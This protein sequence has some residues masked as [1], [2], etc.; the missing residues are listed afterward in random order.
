VVLTP[1]G[2]KQMFNKTHNTISTNEFLEMTNSDQEIIT[3]NK[4][5]LIDDILSLLSV[6][7]IFGVIFGATLTQLIIRFS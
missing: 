2:G 5:K 7:F 1:N 6:A 4:S 3:V